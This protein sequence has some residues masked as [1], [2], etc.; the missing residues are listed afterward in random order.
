MLDAGSFGMAGA[1]GV[2]RWGLHRAAGNAMK[3]SMLPEVRQF[4][5]ITSVIAHGFSCREQV[6]PASDQ[7][8]EHLAENIQLAMQ[9]GPHGP[10]SDRP[11]DANAK[12]YGSS[13]SVTVAV[14][15]AGIALLT[16]LSASIRVSGKAHES[17]IAERIHCKRCM[18]RRF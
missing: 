18:R 4:D 12:D 3:H 17:E 10:T 5:E 7:H 6:A 8:V 13:R 14:L 16:G 15:G 2:K 1:F 9:R 11:E